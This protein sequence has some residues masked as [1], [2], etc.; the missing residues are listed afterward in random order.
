MSIP[1]RPRVVV[2]GAGSGLGRGFALELAKRGARIVAADIDLA[3]AEE[4]ARMARERGAEVAVERCDVSKAEDVEALAKS[5]ERAFG[6]VDLL[7]NNA[8]V[9]V[10][11][12]VGDIELE[13]WRWIVSINL[14]GVVHGCHYFAPLMKKARSGHVINVASAAGLV[15]APGMAP[16]NMTKF[17]V[18][19]LSEALYGELRPH[20]VGVTVL[21]PTFFQTNILEAGRG[22]PDPRAKHVAAKLMA[23][24][25]LDASDVARA[26]LGAADA[27]KLYSVPMG[28]GRMMWA[29]KRLAP[30]QWYR[31]VGPALMSLVSRRSKQ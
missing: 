30:E 28:D 22:S 3:G 14:M 4:T 12:E 18:V 1:S 29:L 16:Y 26:A 11:G 9:A 7:V 19:G 8:G 15:A 21:C 25:K 20:G 27:G 24:S 17:G 13:H 31:R 6:G 10:A 5:A 23:A 2:T